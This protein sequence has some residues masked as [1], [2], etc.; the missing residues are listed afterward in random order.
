MLKR[1]VQ[2][3]S[4]ISPKELLRLSSRDCG[5]RILPPRDY[6]GGRNTLR[7]RGPRPRRIAYAGFCRCGTIMG[8]GRPRTAT[9]NCVRY[10]SLPRDDRGGM[11]TSRRSRPTA[12]QDC[13]WSVAVAGALSGARAVDGVG[14]VAVAARI[15]KWGW[16]WPRPGDGTTAGG[17]G[18]GTRGG[19]QLRRSVEPEPRQPGS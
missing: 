4:Q 5:H 19:P 18:P 3:P 6:R 11:K 2:L 8:G 14:A 13:G 16:S 9:Q 12:A 7:R 10:I 1:A 17:G 15:R